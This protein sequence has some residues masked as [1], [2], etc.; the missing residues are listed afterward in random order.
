MS[1]KRLKTYKGLSGTDNKKTLYDFRGVAELAANSFRVTQ[2]AER[3]KRDSGHGQDRAQ[4]IAEN[5]GR[6]VRNL[7]MDDGGEAP[8]NLAL[9]DH[10]SKGRSS[11]KEDQQAVG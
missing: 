7:M 11:L 1:L 10:I 8:E 3:L 4:S 6:E 5:V 9:E 2:T